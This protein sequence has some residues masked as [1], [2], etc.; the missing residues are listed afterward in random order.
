[1]MYAMLAGLLDPVKIELLLGSVRVTS[2]I[3]GRIRCY[4]SL[5]LNNEKNAGMLEN[6]FRRQE[7]ISEYKINTRTGS[8]LI[9]YKD[10]L[11]SSDPFLQKIANRLEKRFLKVTAR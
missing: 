1:M 5:I 2:F 7:G 4:S 11:L 8:V 6:L 9:V 10:C 3:P